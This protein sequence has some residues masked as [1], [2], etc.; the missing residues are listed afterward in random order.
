MQRHLFDRLDIA[1]TQS[2]IG[3]GSITDNVYQAFGAIETSPKVVVFPQWPAQESRKMSQ[4][5]ALQGPTCASGPERDRILRTDAID[6]DFIVLADVAPL[7]QR[8]RQNVPES[9]A[10]VVQ[11]YLMTERLRQRFREERSD[12]VVE[13]LIDILE[14]ELI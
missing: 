5:C 14:I 1:G 2:G 10:D 4:L 6:P 12:D 9:E 3:A 13:L 11:H 7:R 8:E